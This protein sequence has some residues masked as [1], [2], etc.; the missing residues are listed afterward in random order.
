MTERPTAAAAGQI[1][2]GTQQGPLLGVRVLELGILLAG[3]FVGRMLGD[4]GA[5]IIKVEAPERGDTLRDW[6]A[7]HLEGRGLWWPV[8]SRNKKL[9]TLN[10][11]LEEGQDLL[12]RL[13]AECDVLVE[14]FRPGTLERWNLSP[15][16]LWE[17]NPGL[18]IARVSGY[19]QNGPY[20]GRAG[21]ASAGEAMG[22]LRYI[23]G[24]PG[25]APPRLG[26]SLGDSLAAMFAAQG[27]LMALYHR[28]AR[29]GKGQVIDASIMESCFSLLESMAPDYDRLGI[30]REP[31]GTRLDGIAPSNVYL[32]GDD[33]W[34][35]IAA[36][37]ENLWERLCKVMEREDLLTDPRFENH[38]A[39]GVHQDELDAIIADWA[40][41]RT[42]TEID[43]ELNAAGV[44]CGPV[45]S[46]ADIFEDPQYAAREA[47]ITM[48]DPD[49]GPL[50][51]PAVHPKLSGTPGA[52]AWTGPW[53]MGKHNDEI[54]GGLLGLGDDE[55]EGLR[56][57][58]VV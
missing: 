5:E 58:G 47:L 3:P 28:D 55:L 33:K 14:N 52:A 49:L 56:E 26:I 54:Y 34:V 43:Q 50:R 44:V 18:V 29:G 35:V 17:V 22:G 42:A 40:R 38:R 7:G 1:T 25:Q 41:E 32:S 8:Q 30:V 2:A 37:A 36:N 27:V 20:A 11:R 31:S 10:L 13:A 48:E 57:R 24:H 23:N 45:Y 4:F 19:G 6:G 21:F 9:V 16:Q 51:A 12:R 53:P 15:E 46:I 39:R